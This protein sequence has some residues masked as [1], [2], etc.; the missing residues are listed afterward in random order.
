MTALWFS[1]ER[2]VPEVS[3]SFERRKYSPTLHCFVSHLLEFFHI[4]ISP[5]SLFLGE[6]E[7]AKMFQLLV[8][9]ST[10]A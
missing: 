9:Y 1:M 10:L 3:S 4:I 8:N 6:Y 7:K 5:K 2:L